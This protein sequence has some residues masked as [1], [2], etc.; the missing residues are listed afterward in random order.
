MV[1]LPVDAD[2]PA[3][4][5]EAAGLVYVSDEEPGWSR[6]RRGRGFSYVG[7][8]GNLAGPEE[9]SRIEE[10]A[11]PPAWTEV[12]IALDP[13]AHVQATGRDDAGRKQY[14]YHDRWRQ[15]RDAM[16]FDRL[17]EFGLRLPEVRS[18]VGGYLADR[19]LGRRRVLAAVTRLLDQ[20][21][22]RV[23]N[24]EYAADNDTYGA[25][26]LRPEHVR[27]S[28]RGMVLEFTAK[29][30]LERSVPVRDPEVRSVIQECLAVAEGDVFCFEADG[31]VVDVT[32]ADVNEFLRELAGDAFTAK[33][34]RTWGGTTH[35][36]GHL[37]PLPL[38]EDP[39][40]VDRDEL[41]AIDAAAEILGNT[42]AV[43]RSCYVAPQVPAAHRAG[44]L[45]EAW[46]ASRSTE[47]MTRPER[48][49]AKVLTEFTPG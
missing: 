47:W 7:P 16:K 38:G 26:T 22:I 40:A 35:A 9:R 49:S 31:S 29:G 30:G 43:A 37:G 42:R 5:A 41:A 18:D 12:W 27:T 24:E 6:R 3:A 33:D 28:R 23:G 48:V 44:A 15:I 11:I 25:T 10:L 36:A 8:D 21:L 45:G 39:A 19:G 4:V 1:D 13:D 32:S 34:F 20:S 14:R 17:A 46:R 2:D